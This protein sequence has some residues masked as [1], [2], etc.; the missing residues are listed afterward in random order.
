MIVSRSIS[1]NECLEP[2]QEI[3]A[4]ISISVA[5]CCERK[6]DGTDSGEFDSKLSSLLWLA[7]S[8]PLLPNLEWSLLRLAYGQ[9]RIQ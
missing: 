8:F 7:Q 2:A 4:S 5:R 1:V 3:D 9:K 6:A